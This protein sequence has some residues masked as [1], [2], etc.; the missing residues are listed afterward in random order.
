MLMSYS[1]FCVIALLSAKLCA[2]QLPDPGHD[3]DHSDPFCLTKADCAAIVCPQNTTLICH[4]LGGHGHCSCPN[5]AEIHACYTDRNCVDACYTHS[6]HEVKCANNFN[7]H[8]HCE[9]DDGTDLL[10]HSHFLFPTK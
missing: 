5:P 6:T 10:T 3:H 4:G 1:F 9:C 8:G 7:D 2:G